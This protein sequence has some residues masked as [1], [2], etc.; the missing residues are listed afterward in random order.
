MRRVGIER[1]VEIIE[2][3][4]QTYKWIAIDQDT[5]QTLLRLYDLHQLRDVCHRL[6]WK[7][8]DVKRTLAKD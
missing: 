1:R 8:V 5:R 2:A 4:N 3:P 6:G 7:V